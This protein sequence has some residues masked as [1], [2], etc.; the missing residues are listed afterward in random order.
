L[1]DCGKDEHQQVESHHGSDGGDGS[2]VSKN[3]YS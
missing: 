2:M 3:G 1:A